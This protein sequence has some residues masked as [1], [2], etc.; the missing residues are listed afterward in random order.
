MHLQFLRKFAPLCSAP[1]NEREERTGPDRT[2]PGFRSADWFLF[3]II[4]ELLFFL[5]SPL[6]FLR[7]TEPTGKSSQLEKH[8]PFHR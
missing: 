4:K 1:G 2:G 3:I 6:G 5:F 8:L 7:R